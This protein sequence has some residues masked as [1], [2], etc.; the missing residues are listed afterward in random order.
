MLEGIH[1]LD[2][3]ILPDWITQSGSDNLSCDAQMVVGV[4][5]KFEDT[6]GS[7][8]NQKSMADNVKF[9]TKI[10]RLLQNPSNN[11]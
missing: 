7:I 9:K 3:L 11:N 5:I 1:P 10:Q 8:I 4:K 6:K 2:A